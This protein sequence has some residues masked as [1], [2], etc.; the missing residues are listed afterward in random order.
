M[1]IREV[2]RNLQW[3]TILVLVKIGWQ[4]S[5]SVK[6]AD[7]VRAIQHL[8]QLLSNLGKVTISSST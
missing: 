4:I 1:D 3:E 5:G 7:G 6:Q 8:R 2:L